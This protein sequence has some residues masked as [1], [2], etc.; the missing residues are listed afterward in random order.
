MSVSAVAGENNITYLSRTGVPYMVY[1]RH[2]P[3]QP[4]FFESQ[5]REAAAYIQFIADFYSCLPEVGF[6]LEQACISFNTA[7]TRML[8]FQV[9]L[10]IHGHRN[11]WHQEDMLQ[12][13]VAL[14]WDRMPGF[15]ELN[16]R[17]LSQGWQIW[18]GDKTR[19]RWGNPIYSGPDVYNGSFP[20]LL[21]RLFN[22]LDIF[23]HHRLKCLA[24]RLKPDKSL[25]MQIHSGVVY[26]HWETHKWIEM[27]AMAQSWDNFFG[28]A[29]LGP[30]PEKLVFPCCAQFAVRKERIMMRWASFQCSKRLCPQSIM[31]NRP[32]PRDF[33]LKAL[34]FIRHNSLSHSN[35]VSKAYMT[36][37]MFERC[38][39]LL[40]LLCLHDGHLLIPG[41]AAGR[42]TAYLGSHMSL[43]HLA[44]AVRRS[45][46]ES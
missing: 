35:R 14:K 31:M 9:T 25:R 3:D 11:A 39:L 10:F 33:Y 15:V 20:P 27:V 2:D 19:R 7:Y 44:R 30:F 4:N 24:A 38:V 28:P 46:V 12:T 1:Q 41:L 23:F 42:G 17:S 34:H 32:R 8:R 37:A 16:R 40:A 6:A 45:I 36:G 26:P 43:C 18:L 22:V 21:V 5:G 29:G 13:I